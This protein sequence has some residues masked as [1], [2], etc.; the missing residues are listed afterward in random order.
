MN[1]LISKIQPLVE[2]IAFKSVDSDESLVKSKLIDSIGVVDLVV[3][4]ENEFNI[5]IDVRDIIEENFETVQKIARYI[6]E[7][8]DE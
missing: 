5:S 3:L 8:I 1:E 4:L 2:D 6:G 7:K